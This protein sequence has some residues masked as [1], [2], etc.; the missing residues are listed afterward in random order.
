[1]DEPILA[2]LDELRDDHRRAEADSEHLAAQAA[3][4]E[5]R[6]EDRFADAGALLVPRRDWWRAP[7][8]L[9]PRLAEAERLV[10]RISAFDRRLTH[11]QS[12]DTHVAG[13]H[14]VR[15]DATRRGR[16]R[17]AAR[18]RAVLVTIARSGVAEAIDVPQVR[19]LL[20][21][22]AEL[23]ARARHLRFS[24]AARVRRLTE[25][26]REIE[27]REQARRLMGFD[28]LHLVACFSRYGLPEIETAY[29][30]EPGEMAYLAADAALGRQPSRS[31]SLTRA[32]R[33]VP[34]T[35]CTGMAHWIGA[36]QDR[37]AP[38]G[39]G[40]HDPGVVLL[41]S[42]RLAFA[43][44]RDSVAIWLDAVTDMD[45]FLDAIAVQHLGAEKPMVLHVAA[46][47]QVVFYINWAMQRAAVEERTR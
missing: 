18:L 6:A 16:N 31:L 21:A 37:M 40:E 4:L 17:A 35:A 10:G 28:A 45:V 47:G 1:V 30:L 44:A 29:E 5:A 8:E 22:A 42:H 15:T 41:T 26:E 14:R 9:V 38:V 7:A 32:A 2:T 39:E 36:F 33:V 11:L 25:L 20:E 3:E 43:G 19:P 13:W 24:L 46:P 27:R 23:Q 12:R 34:S